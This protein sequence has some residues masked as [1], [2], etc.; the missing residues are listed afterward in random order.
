MSEPQSPPANHTANGKSRTVASSPLDPPAGPTSPRRLRARP[1]RVPGDDADVPGSPADDDARLPLRQAAGVA[2]GTSRGE[3]TELDR[4]PPADA[5]LH[6]RPRSLARPPSAALPATNGREVR[7]VTPDQGGHRGGS[8]S[9]S[10]ATAPAIPS[11]SSSS[12]STSRPTWASTRSSEW[13]SWASSATPCRAWARRVGSDAMET[14]ARA[15]TLGAIVDRV[16]R[17][18]GQSPVETARSDK[19]LAPRGSLPGGRDERSQ[20]G[21]R[22]LLLEAVDAP[23]RAEAVSLLPGGMVLVTDDGR[24]VAPAIAQGLNA[25]GYRTRILGG[26]DSGLD[27]TSPASIESELSRARRQGQVTGL[28]H[29][30]PLR[31]A[32]DPGCDPSAWADRMSAEV[33][34]LFLLAKGLAQDLETAARL[35]RRLP[36]LRDGPGRCLRESRR[37]GIRSLRRAG[38]HRGHRQDAGSG[39]AC[40]AHARDRHGPR[41]GFEPGGPPPPDRGVPRRRLD[42]GR[43]PRRSPHPITS[44]SPRRSAMR[45]ADFALA[46]GE[47]VV[48]TGGARGITALV[49]IEM[50]R[51][52]QPTLLLIG[53]TPPPSDREDEGLDG[54]DGASEVKARLYERLSRSGRSVSPPELERAY[55]SLRRSREVHENLERMRA[56]GAGS[57]TR[58]STSATSTDLARVLEEWR[59]RFGEP[60]GLI[61]GAGFIKDKLIRDKSVD[62]FDR[63]LG[64][65]LDGALNLIH[66]LRHEPAPVRRLLLVDRGAVRQRRPVGLRRGERGH[67]QAGH[68]ARPPLARP[69]A[70]PDLGPVVGD[71]HGLRAGAA[72]RRRRAWA[73]SPPRRASPPS[74]TSCSRGR[75]GEVEVVLAGELGTLD[76]PMERARRRVE[77]RQ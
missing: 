72:S 61:H 33:R 13:R 40:G 34:G 75:K 11:K 46:A 66:C 6:G 15:K 17:I 41:S 4:L 42:G 53:T 55:Q 77:A 22:R 59:R 2:D 24:G 52:W 50:A 49:G 29:A 23:L 1:G 47:P 38:G 68:P 57:S 70:G 39:V 30:L 36:G 12:S 73:R 18:L 43:L 60:V 9:G 69:R 7:L 16:E 51:R 20:A 76:A 44:G 3:P 5:P 32:G 48:I 21:L 63:V 54:L 19:P 62:V 64:T 10:S 8:C 74:W 65:K 35:G 25:K 71:R 37:L 58:R 67:E 28:I 14:L 31:S 56:M 27:W 26:P 45:P